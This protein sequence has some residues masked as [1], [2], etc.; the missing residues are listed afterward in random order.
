MVS[1]VGPRAT[2]AVTW[3]STPWRTLQP[4]TAMCLVS[5]AGWS[6]GGMESVFVRVLGS[7]GA[8]SEPGRA[9]SSTSRWPTGLGEVVVRLP[10]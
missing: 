4:V 3:T 10:A 8:G 1:P 7:C 2:P 9:C 6:S 5:A